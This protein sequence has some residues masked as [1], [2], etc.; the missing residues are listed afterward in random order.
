M[1]N[2]KYVK[3]TKLMEFIIEGTKIMYRLMPV[4]HDCVKHFYMSSMCI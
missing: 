1:G 2:N 3:P 4:S